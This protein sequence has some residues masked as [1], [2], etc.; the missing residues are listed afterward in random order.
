MS[1]ALGILHLTRRLVTGVCNIEALS[2]SW[3]LLTPGMNV[4]PFRDR[5]PFRCHKQASCII[6]VQAKNHLSTE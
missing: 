5:S 2:N 3:E 4:L 1:H 6:R